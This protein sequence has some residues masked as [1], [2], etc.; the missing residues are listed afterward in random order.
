[1]HKVF[2]QTGL[3]CLFIL[4]TFVANAQFNINTNPFWQGEI[5]MTDGSI[6]SG[7][8]QVPNIAAERK[9]AYKSAQNAKSEEIKR[10]KISKIHV[11]SEN[12]KSFFYDNLPMGLIK[13]DKVSKKR[14]L[15]LAHASNNFVTFYIMSTYKVNG[16]TGNIDFVTKYIQG[17]DFPT[18]SYFMSKGDKKNAKMYYMT[19]QLGGIKKNAELHFAE[20]QNL[21][22]KIKNKELKGKDVS[23]IIQ[24]FLDTTE[25]M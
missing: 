20:D 25:N 18:F 24:T 3:I 7:Y 11:I 23:E 1:M 10:E 19:K 4:S 8:I 12:G 14:Y 21:V 5:E 22:E 9:I 13:K 6:K 17:K 2:T 15:L 16:R